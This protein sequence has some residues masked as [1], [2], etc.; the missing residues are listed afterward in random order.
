M[1]DRIRRKLFLS[2][3]IMGS[4]DPSSSGD[5]SLG[6]SELMNIL[7]KGS[8]A[9]S[10]ANNGMDLERFLKADLTEILA[11]SRSLEKQRDVKV[12]QDLNCGVDKDDEQLL[13]DAE[14]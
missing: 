12:K 6:M 5:G 3:K 8:S 2:V 1:L 4:D 14:E 9:L 10:N 13:L 11:H 7:R